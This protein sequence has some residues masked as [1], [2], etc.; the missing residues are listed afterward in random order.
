M[1]SAAVFTVKV[2]ARA[3]ARST[4]R[5]GVPQSPAHDARSGCARGADRASLGA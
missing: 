2:A 1:S 5:I 3:V 4:A